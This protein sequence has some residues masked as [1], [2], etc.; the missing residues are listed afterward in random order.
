MSLIL[1]SLALA[2]ADLGP[3]DAFRVNYAAVK[4]DLEYEFVSGSMS[5]ADA[6][7]IWENGGSGLRERSETKLNGRWSCDGEGEYF[8]FGSPDEVIAAGKAALKQDIGQSVLHSTGMGRKHGLSYIPR[9][10]ALFDGVILA[11]HQENEWANDGGTV[12]N[13]WTDGSP[14]YVLLGK[15]PF[16]YWGT[17]PFPQILRAH[18]PGVKPERRKLVRNGRPLEVEIYKKMQSAVD[19]L[20]IEID[21]D[22]SVA[23]LPRHIRMVNFST[24]INTYISEV[25]VTGSKPCAAGGFVPTEWYSVMFGLAKFG[26]LYPNYDV[27]TVLEPTNEVGVGRFKVTQFKDRAAPVALTQLGEINSIASAGGKVR[28]G[29]GVH[30]LTLDAIKS[31]MGRKLSDPAPNPLPSLDIAEVRQYAPKP[32][33]WWAMPLISGFGSFILLILTGFL[34][35]RRRI[36]ALMLIVGFATLPG[37]GPAQKPVFQMSATFSPPKLL[38]DWQSPAIPLVLTVRNDGTHP[39]RILSVDGGCACR[40]VDQSPLP[41]VL[42][43][44]GVISFKVRASTKKLSAPQSLPFNVETDQGRAV[45][46]AELLEDLI[47]RSRDQILGSRSPWL[48]REPV[49]LWEMVRR[50]QEF[51]GSTAAARGIGCGGGGL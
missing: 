3:L 36:R 16:L 15:S 18:F 31:R 33:P 49:A 9:T 10:E 35:R 11:G 25:Y 48:G 5:P 43:P 17:Y 39:V 47:S 8:E 27:E 46:G 13:V 12:I 32:S 21:Y 37:C 26:A 51:A 20:Q 2:L 1:A 34:W 4:V 22:P 30:S 42:S 29:P 44:G 38:Y 7:R 14:G 40:Q 23:Y 45:V 28:I 24:T 19:W 41:A 6:A 50:G